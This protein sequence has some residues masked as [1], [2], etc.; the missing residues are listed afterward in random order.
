MF[1]AINDGL[2]RFS[3]FKGR[4]T[5]MQYISFLLFFL[6]VDIF[7]AIFNPNGTT[8]NSFIV[9]ALF[10]PM[11]A[12]EIRRS[13]DVGKSGWWILVP[14]YSIYLMFKPSVPEEP[15]DN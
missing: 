11:I 4:S 1:E 12:V 8:I 14:F 3:D 9:A 13:H 10:V 6:M 7:T 5:R 2:R 15:T